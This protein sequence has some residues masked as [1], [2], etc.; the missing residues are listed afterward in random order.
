M[1]Y[2]AREVC[3]FNA[4]SISLHISILIDPKNP[5]TH[6]NRGKDATCCRSPT[7]K[8]GKSHYLFNVLNT[9]PSSRTRISR[10]LPFRGWQG[11]PVIVCVFILGREDWHGKIGS[12][13]GNK[14]RSLKD[15]NQLG[16][17]EQLSGSEMGRIET[18][19]DFF[20][21]YD[22]ILAGRQTRLKLQLMYGILAH[23]EPL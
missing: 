18:G 6:L 22:A 20:T 14:Q 7:W 23:L 1:E 3:I 13:S 4:Q 12:R 2:S 5:G 17:C 9:F 21:V 11:R 16:T 8:F 15:C 19:I 10:F